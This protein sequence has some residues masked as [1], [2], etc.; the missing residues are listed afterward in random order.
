M[1]TYEQI[2][3]ALRDAKDFYNGGMDGDYERRAG[4]VGVMKEIVDL[5]IK[6]GNGRQ[7]QRG[8]EIAVDLS[9]EKIRE[10]VSG[11]LNE[12]NIDLI[13]IR[14]LLEF[15]LNCAVRQR[16]LPPT[17]LSLM[18]YNGDAKFSFR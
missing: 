4:I 9:L 16:N 17:V 5:K 8:L 14:D 1:I 13:D 10:R 15:F 11:T 3:G 7:G 12:V 6:L 2:Q 18:L